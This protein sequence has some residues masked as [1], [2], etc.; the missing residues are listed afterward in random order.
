MFRLERQLQNKQEELNRLSVEMARI[1][2]YGYE[3][4]EENHKLKSDFE[5][6]DMRFKSYKL[7]Q[8]K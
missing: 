8:Q 2:R 3:V 7:R 5:K 4:H 6:L 1:H